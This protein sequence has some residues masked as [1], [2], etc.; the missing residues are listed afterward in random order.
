MHVGQGAAWAQN[1]LKPLTVCAACQLRC[2]RWGWKAGKPS[3]GQ[4]LQHWKR[5]KGFV[6]S[7]LVLYLNQALLIISLLGLI[8]DLAFS[9]YLHLLYV[10]VCLRLSAYL[11]SYLSPVHIHSDL[12]CLSVMPPQ[13]PLSWTTCICLLSSSIWATVILL[14]S[15]IS[16]PSYLMLVL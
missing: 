5:D 7:L 3:S 6:L 2:S 9:F 13:L 16:T 15:Q 11:S 4:H 12:A 1:L 10:S 8:I 14:N